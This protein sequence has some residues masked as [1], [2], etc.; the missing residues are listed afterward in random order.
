MEIQAFGYLGLGASNLDDW[1]AFSMANGFIILIEAEGDLAVL[2]ASS[3]S[4]EVVS[5]ASVFDM[6]K[7]KDFPE[8][9]P[10]TCWTTPVLCNGKIYVRNTYGEIVCVDMR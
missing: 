9:Q 5:R 7:N 10:L 3:K 2:K 8:G 1:A 6:K 4:Y